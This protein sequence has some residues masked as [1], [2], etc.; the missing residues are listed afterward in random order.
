MVVKEE[1]HSNI[2]NDDD[3]NLKV[4]IDF[5]LR[6]NKII[7]IFILLG[8]ILGFIKTQNTQNLASEFQI[9]VSQK[10]KGSS[11]SNNSFLP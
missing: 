1:Y 9:V 6:N 2:P 10:D 5:F 11:L 3:I 7:L 8:T 4:F